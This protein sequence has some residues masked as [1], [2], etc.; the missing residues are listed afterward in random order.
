MKLPNF[1]NPPEAARAW[2]DEYEARMK[3]EKEVRLALEAKEKIEKEK[4]MVQAELNTA[5]DTI[6]EN[7]PVI[8]MFKRSI[9][10]SRKPPPLL[11]A[12]ERVTA[13]APSGTVFIGLPSTPYSR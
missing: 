4:R 1:N 8:D 2:A 10:T 3:A 7:E 13:T 6:K 5:I 12:R 9:S 11:A